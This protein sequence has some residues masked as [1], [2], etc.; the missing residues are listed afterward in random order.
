[1]IRAIERRKS[2]RQNDSETA[3]MAGISVRQLLDLPALA[4]TTVLAGSRGLDRIVRHVTVLEVPPPIQWLRGGELVLTTFF[5]VR[6]DL[7]SQLQVLR[8]MDAGGAAAIGFHPGNFSASVPDEMLALAD[9]LGIPILRVPDELNYIDVIDPIMTELLSRRD[10]EPQVVQQIR[11]ELTRQVL[12]GADLQQIVTVFGEEIRAIVLIVDSCGRVRAQSVHPG[13]PGD[14]QTALAAIPALVRT[15]DEIERE[16][17]SARIDELAAETRAGVLPGEGT[18]RVHYTP[19]VLQK[20]VAAMVVSL[21]GRNAILSPLYRSLYRELALAA[22]LVLMREREHAEAARQLE[23][24]V[25]DLLLRVQPTTEFVLLE[26]ARR[27]G[28][29]LENCSCAMVFELERKHTGRRSV[30]EGDPALALR[31]LRWAVA[32]ADETAV[33]IE[34]NDHVLCLPGGRHLDDDRLKE[35]NRRIVADVQRVLSRRFPEFAVYVTAGPRVGGVL[36]LK[37]SYERALYTRMIRRQFRLTAPLLFA[38]ELAPYEALLRMAELPEVTRLYDMVVGPLAAYDQAHGSRLVET[39]IAYVE[40]NRHLQ[41]T[42][43]ALGVHI[44]TVRKRLDRIAEICPVDVRAPDQALWV[45]LC[46]RL[47]ATL[48]LA[49]SGVG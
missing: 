30:R 36:D 7:Q 38:D 34:V 14:I 8:E 46:A 2:A 48:T 45:D 15:M 12:R 11:S 40:Q 37:S 28:W 29:D 20:Q 4:G 31:E 35:R 3:H 42:A 43:D 19:I 18:H 6:G 26:R 22:A 39:L 44:N 41:R 21:H 16:L 13:E 33:V 32:S 47:H 25:L 24:D 23:E 5:C 27:L 10:P 1:M 17:R 49:H 9:E